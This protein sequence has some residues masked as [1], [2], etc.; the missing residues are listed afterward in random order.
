MLSK[1]T[2][3]S[4]GFNRAVAWELLTT[5]YIY[6]VTNVETRCSVTICYLSR[7]TQVVR[8]ICNLFCQGGK[9]QSHFSDKVGSYT[10]ER[11]LFYLLG[12]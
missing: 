7:M 2:D 1:Y 5:I 11:K 9:F 4:I 10:V 12:M 3:S 8:T 6:T